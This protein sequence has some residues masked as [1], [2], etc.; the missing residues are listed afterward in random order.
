MDVTCIKCRP[1]GCNHNP[2]TEFETFM[3]DRRCNICKQD[4]IAQGMW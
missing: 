3:Y 2:N 4:M 1:L